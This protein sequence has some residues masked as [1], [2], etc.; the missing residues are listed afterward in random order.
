MADNKQTQRPFDGENCVFKNDCIKYGTHDCFNPCWR[1]REFFF[2]LDNSNLPDRYKTDIKLIPSGS[3]LKA[4]EY[5]DYIRNN[6]LDFVEGGGSLVISGAT[7][8]GKTTWATKILRRYLME[9]SIANGYNPRA[10]FVNMTWFVTQ[11]RHNIHSQSS[12]FISLR[13]SLYNIDLLVFDDIGATKIDNSFIHD[14][15]FSIINHR[16]DNGFCTIYTTNLSDTELIEVLGD[17][18]SAR[19]LNLSQRV[20]I[21]NK[22]DMRNGESTTGK[23]FSFNNFVKK[24]NCE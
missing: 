18:L 2:L 20:A 14:E 19:I 21:K 1:Q 22:T 24:G 8:T 4:F 11:I 5:L 12:N 23:D 16:A 7:G 10:L 15:I 9:V 6:V 3:D 17:R 13:D